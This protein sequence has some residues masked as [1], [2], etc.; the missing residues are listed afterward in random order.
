MIGIG[1]HTD[2]AARIILHLSALPE[3][4]QVTAGDIAG[5]RLLP[6]PFMRR[7]V[8]QLAAAGILRT[9]RGAGGGIALA[10]PA[11]KISLLDVMR[12]MEGDLV[13]NACVGQPAGCPLSAACTVQ[14]AWTKVTRQ[15]EKTLSDI[16]FD[17]L[18]N[19][20]EREIAKGGYAN[21]PGSKTGSLQ[22][23]KNKKG[24]KH[25]RT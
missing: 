6:R 12:A 2:Y 5:E 9:I 7:I 25:G 10:R 15:L 4:T 22:S 20:I 19:G 18:A 3:G 24:G 23:L 11:S 14:R 8:V 1:R 16:R 21:K 17:R 13:L